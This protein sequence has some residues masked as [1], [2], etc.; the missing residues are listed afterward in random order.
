MR[1]FLKYSLLFFTIALFC[2]FSLAD[3]RG[4]VLIKV[5]DDF[6]QIQDAYPGGTVFR[7][8]SGIHVK[9][10]V[11]NPK[12]GNKWVGDKGA[13]LDGKNE[14][15]DAFHGRAESITIKGLELRNYA[16]NGI[17][18]NSG[19]KV[20]IDGVTVRDSG[21]G[22]G[23][24]NGSVRFDGMRDIK[25]INCY[26]NRVSSGVL[27]TRCRGPIIIEYNTGVNTG[28]NF[29][30][31]AKCKGGGIRVRYNSMERIGDY[32]R[33]GAEDVEDWISVFKVNGLTDDPVKIDYNRAR[34]HGPSSSGS[35]IMLGDS[36]G[37]YQ[38]AVGNIGVNPGQVGIGLSGGGH[39]EV[40]ENLMFSEPWEQSNVAFYSCDNSKRGYCG[41]HVVKG[42]RANWLNRE[43]I[44]NAFWTD[45]TTKPITIDGNS[46]PDRRLTKK[47]WD[48]WE[49]EIRK[50]Q[51]E[52]KKAAR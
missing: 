46:F 19:S 41:N 32:L 47:I 18:F 1:V 50:L 14:I 39:I 38:Q 12:K 42:N 4:G 3:H 28:R 37:S 44:Q 22:S 49:K 21:S 27:P 52:T 9:Q 5:G 34:G 7:V 45:G 35:F 36:G 26:F 6:Q 43:G 48:Q 29:V 10:R 40:R 2:G 15:S 31:L 30:Q 51:N 24:E 13:I 8:A 33:P 25:V 17:Y 23:E 11:I 20:V 16:D